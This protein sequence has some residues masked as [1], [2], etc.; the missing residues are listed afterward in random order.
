MQTTNDVSEYTIRYEFTKNNGKFV[1]YKI[2]LDERTMT[3]KNPQVNRKHDSWTRLDYHQC[4]HC[5]LSKH[6]HRH[7]PAAV[8]VSELFDDWTDAHPQDE[9][10]VQCRT[11]QR[12]I[13]GH[14][15]VQVALGGLM[16]LAMATSE[17]PHFDFFKPMARFHVPFATQSE[18][19]YR[20]LG[21]YFIQQ[22]FSDR[23]NMDNVIKDIEKIYSDLE[24]INQALTKRLYNVQDPFTTVS[25][26]VFLDLLA[27]LFMLSPQD[28]LAEIEQLFRKAS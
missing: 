11:P 20:V 25:A 22:F 10:H 6:E 15:P 1:R 4:S 28:S 12:K 19:Y 7:C 24:I 21:T 18:S 5:P 17:C 13:T 23:T 3:R 27:K 9:V 26:I 2:N 14:A 16:G 8:A